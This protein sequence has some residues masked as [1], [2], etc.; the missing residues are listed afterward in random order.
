MSK[1]LFLS[2][3]IPVLFYDKGKQLTLSEKLDAVEG[4]YDL[5]PKDLSS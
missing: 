5:K 1:S 3:I 2:V 4:F